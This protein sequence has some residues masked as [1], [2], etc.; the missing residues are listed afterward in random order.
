MNAAVGSNVEGRRPVE[1]SDLQPLTGEMSRWCSKL[2][3]YASL[4]AAC[5]VIVRGMF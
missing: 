4:T 1:A 3:G 5:F 2:L